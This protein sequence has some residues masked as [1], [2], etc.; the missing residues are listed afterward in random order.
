MQRF[1]RSKACG[2]AGEA[3]TIT[4]RQVMDDLADKGGFR[5]SAFQSAMLITFANGFGLP[6]DPLTPAEQAA[7]ETATNG[8]PI[9][10]EAFEFTVCCGRQS[11]KSG[12]LAPAA[13]L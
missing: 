5:P 10:H 8:R 2:P 13:V 6:P 4:M 3:M 9:P 11:F 7:L 1:L 12:L